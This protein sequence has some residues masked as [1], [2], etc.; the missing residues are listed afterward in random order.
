MHFGWTL[1]STKQATR[2]GSRQDDALDLQFSKQAC[3]GTRYSAC[4]SNTRP[5]HTHTHPPP[6]HFWSTQLTY[7]VSLM[8]D[9][10]RGYLLHTVCI[11]SIDGVRPWSLLRLLARTGP[12]QTPGHAKAKL[13]TGGCSVSSFVRRKTK[14]VEF[15]ICMQFMR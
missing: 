3:S 1:V 9:W 10:C 15:Q 4:N 14:R 6:A 12:P 7:T 8:C 2:P 13:Q 11:S 5:S